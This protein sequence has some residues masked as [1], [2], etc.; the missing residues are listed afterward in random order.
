M[1]YNWDGGDMFY[2]DSNIVSDICE[3]TGDDISITT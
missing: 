1:N 2:L 3:C